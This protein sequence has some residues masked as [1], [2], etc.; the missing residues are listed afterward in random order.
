MVGKFRL[1]LDIFQAKKEN[2][3]ELSEL[4]VYLDVVEERVAPVEA[5]ARVVHGET[6]GPA[7]QHVAEHLQY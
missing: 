3:L 4:I 7:E 5:V 1:H 2:Y 6:V